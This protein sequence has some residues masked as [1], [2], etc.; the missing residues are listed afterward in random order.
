[1]ITQIVLVKTVTAVV[2]ALVKTV[3]SNS[4]L[5]LNQ[6]PPAN[7][8]FL[9]QANKL[10]TIMKK[11]FI[12]VLF[13]VITLA[14]FAQSDTTKIEQYCQV[15]VTPRLLSNKVTIDIDFGEEKSVWAD[16]RIRT[17]DGKLK[18]FNTVVDALNFMG[19]EGWVFINAYP[20]F[21]GNIEIYHFAFK[22]QF[23]REEVMSDQM[24]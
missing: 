23:T 7:G 18:K 22:K 1:V 16:S 17:Y 5:R 2:I 21:N 13:Q 11:A 20:V 3:V 15:I 19:K 10:I 4:S 8:G 9:N 14:S 12:F 24:K 6:K